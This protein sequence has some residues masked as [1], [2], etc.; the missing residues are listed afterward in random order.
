[1]SWARLLNDLVYKDT[2]NRITKGFMFELYVHH[3]F[4]KGGYT[5]KIKKLAESAQ[6]AEPES[7]F[8]VPSNPRVKNIR[9]IDELSTDLPDEDPERL[10]EDS[11]EQGVSS[12]DPPGEEEIDVTAMDEDSQVLVIPNIPNFPVADFFLM[13]TDIFQVTISEHHPI[14]Q[15]A[16][17]EIIEQMPEY[18]KRQAKFRFFFVV[19]ADIYDKY[20]LQSYSTSD[21]DEAVS[22]RVPMVIQNHIDQYVLKINLE[23]AAQNRSP[24]EGDSNPY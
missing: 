17:V 12:Q 3:L 9:K 18:Q 6:A 19:P 13:P 11:S 10:V 8:F 4:R 21:K 23:A 14:K 16:L 2:I 5:F 7:D 22:Q 1:M 20:K 24:G 15:A